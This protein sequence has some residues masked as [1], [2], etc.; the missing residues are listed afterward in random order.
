[1]TAARVLSLSL[2]LAACAP[3]PAAPVLDWRPR[4]EPY[5]GGRWLL[6]LTPVALDRRGSTLPPAISGTLTL[7]CPTFAADT[8]PC[9]AVYPGGHTLDL[10]PL[11]AEPGDSVSAVTS[12]SGLVTLDLTR[13]SDGSLTFPSAGPI[14]RGYVSGD[15]LVGEWDAGWVS[16]YFVMRRLGPS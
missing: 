11:A 5:V 2:V 12:G 3:G 1:M 14:L 6:T 15:S 16:G 7:T 8:L 9:A 10:S 13:R 4:P